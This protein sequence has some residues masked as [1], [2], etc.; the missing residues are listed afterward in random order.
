MSTKKT[1]IKK[2]VVKKEP[3]AP[4]ARAIK[5]PKFKLISY[6]LKAVIPTGQYANIQPEITVQAETI[7][8]AERAVMPYIETL[9][10]KYRDGGV[11]PVEPV[12]TRPVVSTPVPPISLTNPAAQAPARNPVAHQV[13]QVP[14]HNLVA[15]VA[16]NQT[17]EAIVLT[18]PFNRAKS[19]IESCMSLEALKLVSDQIEKSTKLIDTEKVE[20]KKLVT[21]KFEQ[22]NGQK[23]V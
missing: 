19:A 5:K 7:E 21:A 6:T 18:V 2:S 1:P 8:A 10:A 4:K 11:K 12:V 14:D 16:Q 15:Q 13:A 9:F 20:L 23:T 17:S 22:L 3:V